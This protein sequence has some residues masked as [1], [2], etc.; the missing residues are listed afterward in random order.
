[1]AA[2][3]VTLKSTS[4]QFKYIT[5]AV[6]VSALTLIQ[7]ERSLIT[8]ASEIDKMFLVKFICSVE[9]LCAYKIVVLILQIEVIII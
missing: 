4:A 7:Y 1:M 2:N 5:Y 8:T 3:N 6:S 9:S